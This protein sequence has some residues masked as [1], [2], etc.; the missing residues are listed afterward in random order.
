MKVTIT[1]EPTNEVVQVGGV[2]ARVWKGTTPE[3][4]SCDVF[5]TGVGVPEDPE[6]FDVEK[7]SAL[8]DL[9][10]RSLISIGASG[11]PLVPRRRRRTRAQA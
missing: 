7:Q 10:T 2:L 9:L 11:P 4:A 1:I 6:R 3:G 8:V 5:V